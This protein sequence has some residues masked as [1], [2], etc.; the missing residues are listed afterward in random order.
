MSAYDA[1]KCFL[2]NRHLFGDPRTEAENFNLYNGLA[3][4]CDAITHL[5]GQIQ[6]IRNDL[7]SINLKLRA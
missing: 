3:N 6:A 2:E 1:K 4:L 7:E 5:E